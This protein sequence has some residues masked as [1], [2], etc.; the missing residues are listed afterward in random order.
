MCM[1]EWMMD[2]WITMRGCVCMYNEWMARRTDG[3]MYVS[4]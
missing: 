3:S 1:Y 2:G 4:D